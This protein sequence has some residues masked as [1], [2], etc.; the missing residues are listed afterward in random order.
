[1]TLVGILTC[2]VALLPSERSLAQGDPGTI[3]TVVGG[4]TGDGLPATDA[5]FGFTEVLGVAT[6]T[7]GNVYVSDTLQNRVRVVNMQGTPIAVLGVTVQ[8][9]AIETVAGNGAGTWGIDGEGGN[10]AD[11]L[12]DGGPA[13][14]ATLYYPA[15][16][17]VDAAG[18]LFIGDK[19]NARVRRVDATGTITTAAGGGWSWP[20]DGGP[21]TEASLGGP[22]DVAVDGDGNLYVAEEWGNRIHLVNTQSTPVTKFGAAVDPGDIATVAGTGEPGWGGDGGPATAARLYSPRGLTADA[23]GENLYIAD[24]END[25]IRR[26]DHLGNI[27]T[28][29]G[30]Q[31]PQPPCEPIGIALRGTRELFFTETWN[32]RVLRMWDSNGDT[33]VTSADEP[34]RNVV[35]VPGEQNFGGDGGPAINAY[36]TIFLRIDVDPGGNL[37]IV[38][39]WNHRVRWVAP[40][41]GP[42]TGDGDIDGDL[43]EL[44]DTVAGGGGPIGEGGPATSA[45]LLLPADLALDGAGNLYIADAGN[46]LIRMVQ[47]GADGMVTAGADAANEIITTVVGGGSGCPGQSDPQGDGCAPTEATLNYPSGVTLDPDG[48]V[49]IADTRYARVRVVNTQ[50][51]PITIASVTIPAGK[52]DKVAGWGPWGFSGDGGLAVNAEL[53]GPED[54]AL[55]A[56]GNFYIADRGNHRV[57]RVDN[58]TGVI[59]TVAGSVTG[60]G[61]IVDGIPATDL[62]ASLCEPTAV[63]LDAAGNLLI[64]DDGNLRVRRVGAGADGVVTGASDEII[65]TVAGGGEPC[66]NKLNDQGDGCA[67]RQATLGANAVRD[68]VLDSAGNLYISHPDPDAVR[69]VVPG[70]NGIIDSGSDEVIHTVV[71]APWGY[72]DGSWWPSGFRGDGGLAC[73]AASRWPNGLLIQPDPVNPSLEHMYV[74]DDWAHR[75]RRVEGPLDPDPDHDGLFTCLGYPSERNL[76]TDPFNPDN[77]GDGCLDGEEAETA[78][79]PKPGS[80]GAYNPLAWYDFYDVPI[81]ANNDPD[82]NGP[83]NQAMNLQ[84]V[85]GVLKY[86]GTSDNGGSN[87]RVD[88]D[89]TK[90]GDWNGDTAVTE[91]GDQVGLRYDR[92][93]GPL[94]NPPFDAGPPSG[95]V[96]LQDVVAVLKQVG[97]ACTGVP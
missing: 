28:V 24:T 89:S 95:A 47:A 45:S 30:G 93:P 29:V 77:D 41:P 5:L 79:P 25:R 39:Q 33:V 61:A 19:G 49:F 18:N 84:D 16:L 37:Y 56:Q 34:P 50:T 9:G 27:N 10:P 90:D 36:F 82:P 48:N 2:V 69:R 7:A 59:T 76:G 91:E 57:R 31:C 94:P 51:A 1:M 67:A 12:G 64:A 43:D 71:Y 62:A 58:A 96:N 23:A 44:I 4:V 42:P 6:D 87:G 65:S 17:A 46:D 8:P 53:A 15:G 78:P 70:A 92:S 52:I 35:G 75:I 83:R 13:T 3:N 22:A 63:L 54:V 55:D 14:A 81:P 20:G 68:I 97:R 74:A 21:A 85:V 80:T 72:P 32:T 86:V 40:S 73:A 26:V 88:Y 11:D 38:D 66:A 60:C